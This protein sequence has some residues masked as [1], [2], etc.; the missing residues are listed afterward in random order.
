MFKKLSIFAST[1]TIMFILSCF[2]V[3]YIGSE[4]NRLKKENIELKEQIINLK[5]DNGAMEIQQ[6]DDKAKFEVLEEDL[7]IEKLLVAYAKEEIEKLAEYIEFMQTLCDA[8]DL[9][10]PYYIMGE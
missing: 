8:N 6:K 3:G 7:A 9:I 5:L 2:F 1:I 10:Y 4:L